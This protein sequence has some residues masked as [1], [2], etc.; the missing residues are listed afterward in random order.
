MSKEQLQQAIERA[1]A[2]LEELEQALSAGDNR[3]I[4]A[5]MAELR[6]E[7]KSIQKLVDERKKRS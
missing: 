7:L 1:Q 3:K 4:G 6:W 5:R 2:L